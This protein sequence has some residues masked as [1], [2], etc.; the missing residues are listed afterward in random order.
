MV[1]KSWVETICKKASLKHMPRLD[2]VS[3]SIEII[4]H[5]WEDSNRKQSEKIVQCIK[6]I[7]NIGE[8]ILS[9]FWS[10]REGLYSNP[11]ICLSG[12]EVQTP[13]FAFEIND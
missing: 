2:S 12:K 6:M 4:F 5:Q 7:S 10:Q 13:F 9:S 11:G 3:Y 1:K 8:V